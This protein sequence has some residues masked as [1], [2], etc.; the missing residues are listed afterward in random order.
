MTLF[1][2]QPGRAELSS[3]RTEGTKMKVFEAQ[4]T[5]VKSSA[6]LQSTQG[7]WLRRGPRMTASILWRM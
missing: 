5:E 7:A 2:T 6:F 3:F 1:K 4:K